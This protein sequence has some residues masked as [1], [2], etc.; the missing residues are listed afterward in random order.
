MA[1]DFARAVP[2]VPLGREL[3]AQ[4][5]AFRR[6]IND[7][8][9]SGSTLEFDVKAVVYA[10]GEVFGGPRLWLPTLYAGVKE[11]GAHQLWKTTAISGMDYGSSLAFDQRKLGYVARDRSKTTCQNTRSDLFVNRAVG[12][13]SASCP[14]WWVKVYWARRCDASRYICTCCEASCD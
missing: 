5:Q 4:R 9:S 2:Y 1:D 6:C 11:T 7:L 14:S 13:R 12:P 8:D 3:S 10:S